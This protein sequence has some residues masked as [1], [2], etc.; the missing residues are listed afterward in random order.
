MEK[1][2]R[3]IRRRRKRS[4][5]A[6][7]VHISF[8]SRSNSVFICSFPSSLLLSTAGNTLYYTRAQGGVFKFDMTS[9]SPT[10]SIALRP[11]M[12]LPLDFDID[13]LA[14]V[15]FWAESGSNKVRRAPMNSSAASG[16]WPLL[17]L[18]SVLSLLLFVDI[19]LYSASCIGSCS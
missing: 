13:P 15:L 17:S 11:T 2:K 19:F 3:M 12:F 6:P 1:R 4:R 10:P 7:F 8:F 18:P 9:S 16:I 14:N 5:R